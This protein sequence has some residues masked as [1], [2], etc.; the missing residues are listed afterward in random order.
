MEVAP[1]VKR[2]Q[3]L[4]AYCL[5]EEP[6]PESGLSP[7]IE[8]EKT[9]LRA[10]VSNAPALWHAPDTTMDER[11]RLLPGERGLRRSSR[12]EHDDGMLMTARLAYAVDLYVF[13]ERVCIQNGRYEPKWL[14]GKRKVLKP[15]RLLATT[16]LVE[17]VCT[18]YGCPMSPTWLLHL[19]LQR[20]LS[21]PAR[22]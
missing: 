1:H 15:D 10:L 7:L 12:E 2:Q 11:K 5:T 3:E 14:L 6:N 17:R 19:K 16:E 4:P 22:T 13:D 8:E 21:N 18:V 20:K 9:D